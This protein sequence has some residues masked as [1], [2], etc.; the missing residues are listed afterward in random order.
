MTFFATKSGVFGGYN[1]CWG[2]SIDKGK[3]VQSK[4]KGCLAKLLTLKVVT[5]S[6]SDGEFSE[7]TNLPK[8][9]HVVYFNI[10]EQVMKLNSE[11]F[12]NSGD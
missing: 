11:R 2:D 12:D 8:K 4:A 9:R 1:T 7:A 5:S 6:S 10:V 3:V